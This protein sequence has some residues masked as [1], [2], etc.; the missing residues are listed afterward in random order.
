MLR[1]IPTIA[2]LSTLVFS[3]NPVQADEAVFRIVKTAL[4][5]LN[6][7]FKK[8]NPDAVKRLM[9]EDHIAVTAYYGGAAS[10]EKQL[11]T[12]GDYKLTEYTPGEIKFIQISADVVL[13]SYP[14]T[15]KG[16]FQGK[17]VAHKNWVTATW[18]RRDGK[19]LEVAYTETA[20]ADK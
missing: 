13:V 16:T 10:K 9:T 15:M 3:S 2:V 18:V 7:A 8:N 20:L 1:S 5:E 6:D 4:E 11:K 12:L 19:W 14:L 17:E